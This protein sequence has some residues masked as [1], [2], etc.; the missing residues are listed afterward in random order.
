M[1]VGMKNLRRRVMPLQGPEG[2]GNELWRQRVQ[3]VGLL[4]FQSL[5]LSLDLLKGDAVEAGVFM[6]DGDKVLPKF[7]EK[8]T[9]SCCKI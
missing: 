2:T 6:A 3:H 9:A 1:M 7:P 4:E 5:Q 8:R